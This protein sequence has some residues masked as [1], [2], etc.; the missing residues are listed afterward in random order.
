MG[1]CVLLTLR[2]EISHTNYTSIDL[3]GLKLSSYFILGVLYRCMV[4]RMHEIIR[5]CYSP[6]L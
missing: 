4:A 1:T 2:T 3:K 6:Q 5:R